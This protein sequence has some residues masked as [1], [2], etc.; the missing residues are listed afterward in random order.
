MPGPIGPQEVV[1]ATML[2]PLLGG[3]LRLVI[4]LVLVVVV[5]VGGLLTIVTARSLPQTSGTLQ[6]W[7]AC[8]PGRRSSATRTG[9]PRSPPTTPHDLFMAQGYVHAS[10]RF[11]QMEVYRRAGA[12]RLSEIFGESTVDQ[13]TYIRTLGLRQAGQRDLDALS[14]R[15]PGGARAYADGV[16]AWLDAHRGNLGLPFVVVGLKAGLGGGLGGYDPAPW[17]PLDS[18]TFAKL[19]ALVLGGNLDSEVFRTAADAR[20]G[21]KALT[22][23]LLPGLP[24]RRRRSRSRRARPARA[25]PAP[26]DDRFAGPADGRR[27]DAAGVGAPATTLRS[28]SAG[29]AAAAGWLDLGRIAGSVTRAHRPRQGGR[30]RAP[31]TASARTT[32]SWARR[33]ARPDTRC[34][35]TTRISG[36]TCR[37]SGS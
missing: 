8:T 11:W 28:S 34:W 22:D 30:P 35:P 3:L 19:Q 20:L 6:I 23:Q 12:G 13:D 32:G 26:P 21:D 7:P 14:P 10:E 1:Q 9:S 29:D 15:G 5:A 33:R 37:P 16:N 2:G 17:T 4:A 25:A 27:G 31:T 18:T 36:S 24:G